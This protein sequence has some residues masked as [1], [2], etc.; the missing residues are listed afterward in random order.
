[1]LVLVGDVVEIISNGVF[2]S[3]VHRAMTNAQKERMSVVMFYGPDLD[4]EIGPAEELTD[5]SRSARY[6]K[7]KGVDYLPAQY[8]HASRGE[9]ALDTLRI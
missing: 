6:K 4:K 1:L 2:K 5:D 3:P 8:E 7:V 9:R